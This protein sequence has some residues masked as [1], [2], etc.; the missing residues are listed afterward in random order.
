MKQ[1]F[2]QQGIFDSISNKLEDI[3]QEVAAEYLNWLDRKTSYFKKTIT[4]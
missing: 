4:K 3:D 1:E 2:N